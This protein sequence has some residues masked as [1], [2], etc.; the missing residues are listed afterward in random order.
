MAL[1]WT[2]K[3]LYG[4]PLPLLASLFMSALTTTRLA[5]T[6]SQPGVMFSLP[7]PTQ[8]PLA[9]SRVVFGYHS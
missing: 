4:S 2:L 5:A 3:K 7:P 8:G 6:V 1:K 9:I